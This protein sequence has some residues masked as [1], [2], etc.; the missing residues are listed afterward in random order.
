MNKVA[1]KGLASLLNL[2]LWLWLMHKI[3]SAVSAS[4]ATWMLF[5]IFCITSLVGALITMA[6]GADD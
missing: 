4:E 1:I 5:Y 6:C 2:S 3:L